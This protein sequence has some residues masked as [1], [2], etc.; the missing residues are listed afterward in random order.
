MIFVT[1]PFAIE[2]QV[3]S[4]DPNAPGAVPVLK[5]NA[6]RR[7]NTGVYTYSTMVSV[8]SPRDR[9]RFPAPLKVTTSVQDWCGQV[10]AQ[11]NARLEDGRLPAPPTYRLREFSYF[12]SE[13]DSDREV[14]PA[15]LEDGLWN[16]LRLD[17]E[18]LP[19]GDVQLVPGSLYSRFAHRPQAPEAARAVLAAP[20]EAGLRAYTVTYPELDRTLTIRFR[21]AFPHLIESWTDRYPPRPGAA[22]LSTTATRTHSRMLPYWERHDPEDLPLRREIGLPEQY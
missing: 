2:P 19:R 20:D 8:F 7:F 13:G 16:Q 6:T 18:S 4:D 5:L 10:F 15:L 1:E 17:P 21:A 22:P 12:Q 14:G 3:K 9:E 11:L